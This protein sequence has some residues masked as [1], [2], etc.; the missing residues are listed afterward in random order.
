MFDGPDGV[1]AEL[2]GQP[3]LFEGVAVDELLVLARERT[4]DGQLEEDAELHALA[5][6]MGTNAGGGGG[7]PA[8][9]DDT[10]SPRTSGGVCSSWS[11]DAARR[12]PSTTC[13][14]PPPTSNTRPDTPAE[15]DPH[16]HTT[17]GEIK[18]GPIVGC[19]PAHA[20]RRVAASGAMAFT[21]T[22]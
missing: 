12:H 15:P 1:E 11:T 5:F 19:T 17:S 20:V 4:W 22:L 16:S 10:R 6:G 8:R 14:T 9:A 18:P 7:T 21:L 13:T 2:V 3:G